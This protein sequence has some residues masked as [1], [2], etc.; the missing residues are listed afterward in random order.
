MR[1][2]ILSGLLKIK[3]KIMDTHYWVRFEIR[4]ET[5][6]NQLTSDEQKEIFDYIKSRIDDRDDIDRPKKLDCCFVN[7]RK[8]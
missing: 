3:I 6:N 7:M 2:R 8:F 4:L 1:V 5:I